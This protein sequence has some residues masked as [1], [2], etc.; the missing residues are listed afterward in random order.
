MIP[1]EE[2]AAVFCWFPWWWPR[3]EASADEEVDEEE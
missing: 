1:D 2:V 3:D